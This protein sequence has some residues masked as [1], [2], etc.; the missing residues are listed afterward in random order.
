MNS[1]NEQLIVF[2]IGSFQR[3]AN[4]TQNQL[5]VLAHEQLQATPMEMTSSLKVNFP[6][7]ETSSADT[8]RA[9]N[10]TA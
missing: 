8:K 4:P 10:A 7:E 3:N 6:I 5:H 1:E 9:A 2:E